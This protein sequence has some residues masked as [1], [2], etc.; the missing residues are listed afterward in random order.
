MISLRNVSY[1]QNNKKILNNINIDFEERK[2][3]LIMGTTGSGK[4]TLLS[5]IMGFINPDTGIISVPRG[6]MQ[7]LR[8]RIGM[9]FQ[10]PEEMFYN[11]TVYEEISLSLKYRGFKKNEDFIYSTLNSLGL[12]KEI[13]SKSPYNLSYGEKRLVA[14]GS[15]LSFSPEWLLLDEPF[16]GLDWEYEKKVVKTIE[17]IKEGRSIIIVSHRVDAIIRLVD[18]VTLIDNGEILFSLPLKKVDWKEVLSRG[19]DIPSTV[20]F[21]M[22]LQK[23]GI[24]IGYPITLSELLKNLK[25]SV[26]A[27]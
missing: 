9:L 3:H 10:F 11:E 25:A 26:W 16:A 19:C 6:N 8:K 21:S 13:L 2:T 4:T 7:E 5:I 12:D 20:K 18:T 27:K 14:L 22:E 15:I 24:N 17:G 1:S 23:K